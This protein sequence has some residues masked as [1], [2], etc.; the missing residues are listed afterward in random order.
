MTN[1]SRANC[2]FRTVVPKAFVNFRVMGYF[3]V[4]VLRPVEPIV[5]DVQRNRVVSRLGDTISVVLQGLIVTL[6]GKLVIQPCPNLQAA[7]LFCA[8][9]DTCGYNVPSSVHVRDVTPPEWARSGQRQLEKSLK[10]TSLRL[11]R[12]RERRTNIGARGTKES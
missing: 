10:L 12:T 9:I 8:I 4:V 6:G 2:G 5:G 7:L 3:G 11:T 1:V